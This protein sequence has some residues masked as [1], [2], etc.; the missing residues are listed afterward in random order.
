MEPVES[1][2]QSESTAAE[3]SSEHSSAAV[4]ASPARVE[5][6][7][8]PRTWE[9]PPAPVPPP[10]LE[11]YKAIVAAAEIDDLHFLARDL[12]GKSVKMVNSS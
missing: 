11:D 3:I 7:R 4:P 6:R 5:R 2:V 8:K 1:Q 10:H 12:R 9:T